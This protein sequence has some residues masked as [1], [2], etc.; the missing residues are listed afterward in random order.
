[1]G[2]VTLRLL[3]TGLQM[4]FSAA[5]ASDVVSTVKSTYTGNNGNL[6]QPEPKMAAIGVLQYTDG[7]FF[8]HARGPH[9]GAASSL[10]NGFSL[11]EISANGTMTRNKFNYYIDNA[12]YGLNAGVHPDY[13]PV[14]YYSDYAY[15][16]ARLSMKYWPNATT[17]AVAKNFAIFDAQL[18]TQTAWSSVWSL[19]TQSAVGFIVYITQFKTFV[20]GN[21]YTVPTMS[22][23]LTSIV[24]DPSSKTFYANLVI[25]TGKQIGRAS[26]RERVSSPV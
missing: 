24:A 9:R 12:Y 4:A 13:G 23:D 1:M 2:A 19:T 15:S 3:K 5:P 22:L 18:T 21:V 6:G 25:V 8:V 26:C 14:S 7:R 11:F 20:G 17:G 10:D 16:Q